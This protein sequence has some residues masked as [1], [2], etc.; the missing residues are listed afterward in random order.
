MKNR[1][2][3]IGAAVAILAVVAV[4]IYYTTRMKTQSPS[5]TITATDFAN[6]KSNDTLKVE[7]NP[8]SYILIDLSEKKLDLN[9]IQ[10]RKRGKFMTVRKIFASKSDEQLSNGRYLSVASYATEPEQ[11]DCCPRCEL[12]DPNKTCCCCEVELGE[13]GQWSEHC[14]NFYGSGCKGPTPEECLNPLP[15]YCK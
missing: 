1:N 9:R 6:L 13:D 10:I 14:G 2:I 5:R 3:L 11:R 12:G 7:L 15:E 8:D 4:V